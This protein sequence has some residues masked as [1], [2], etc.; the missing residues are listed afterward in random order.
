[1]HSEVH[2]STKLPPSSSVSEAPS[3]FGACAWIFAYFSSFFF[4]FCHA[5]TPLLLAVI[6]T[7]NQSVEMEN[8]VLIEIL[9]AGIWTPRSLNSIC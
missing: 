8:E 4:F 2:L 5:L 1:M 9:W 3:G 7:E 6:I